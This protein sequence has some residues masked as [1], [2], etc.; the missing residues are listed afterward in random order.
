MDHVTAPATDLGYS[1]GKADFED[2]WGDGLT[3]WFT[4]QVYASP[5]KNYYVSTPGIAAQTFIEDSAAGDLKTL[6]QQLQHKWFMSGHLSKWYVSMNIISTALAS[7]TKA[8]QAAF[9]FKLGPQYVRRTVVY[10]LQRKILSEAHKDYPDDI[11]FAYI[12]GDILQVYDVNCLIHLAASTSAAKSEI[13]GWTMNGL[14]MSS[15]S[16]D[17]SAY[18]PPVRG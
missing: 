8:H 4:N 18:R 16:R 14:F 1:D 10:P 12:T 17:M 13:G 6:Y 11:A 2:A 5:V 7:Y 3:G 15:D 9:M